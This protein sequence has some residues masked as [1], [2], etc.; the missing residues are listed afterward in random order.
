M[1]K[2]TPTSFKITMVD[3]EGNTYVGELHLQKKT[4]S[5]KNVRKVLNQNK[6]P[7][8]TSSLKE[9]YS[10]NFFRQKRKLNEVMEKLS[11][12][13]YNFTIARV[14]KA[15]DRA[16]YLQ[17]GGQRLNYTYIQKYPP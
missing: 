15:M 6:P 8:P 14:S 9:L 4:K 17:Q 7:T 10:E 1:T 3:D 2:D 13:G 11:S 5:V 16:K 12:S